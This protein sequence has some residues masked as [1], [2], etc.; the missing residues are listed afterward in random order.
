MIEA[1]AFRTI[2]RVYSLFKGERLSADFKLTLHKVPSRSVMTYACPPWEFAAD[3]DILKL[4]RLQ[5][6][7][8]HTI[9]EFPKCTSVHELHVAF[10]APYICDYIMKLQ[11][12]GRS[13]TKS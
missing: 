9:G 6:K 2:I 13:H 5:N 10:Q 8:L 12:T 1:K 3:T 4:Q 11:A 7:V